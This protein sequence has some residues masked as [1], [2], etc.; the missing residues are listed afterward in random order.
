MRLKREY[1]YNRC[2][3]KKQALLSFLLRELKS[4]VQLQQLEARW[5]VSETVVALYGKH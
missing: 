5:V 2:V 4:T 1:H 3:M